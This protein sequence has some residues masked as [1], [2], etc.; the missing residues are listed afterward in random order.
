MKPIVRAAIYARYSS[1]NQ[2][3]ESITAQ[4]RACTE[5]CT[6]HDYSVVLTYVD[7]ARSALTDDR[8][9]FQRMIR[10]AKVGLFD[11]LVIHKLD[12]FARSRYDSAFYKREL[13]RASVRL[14]S[15]LERLDGSP[16]SIV[17]ESVLEGMAEYY[18]R[19]LAREIRKGMKE[20]AL[21]CKHNGGLPPLG[22]DVDPD[23]QYVINPREAQTVR[24]I[25]EMYDK[26]KTYS[27]I[28]EELH[29][30]GHRTKHGK[31][32][33]K[34]SLYSIL[35]NQKYAGIYIFNR[36]LGRLDGKF[37][38]RQIKPP[39]QII[40]VPGGIPAIID[41]ELFERVRA[42]ME[43]RKNQG[44]KARARAKQVYLLSGLIFCGKC[45]AAYIGNTTTNG[46]GRQYSFYECGARDRTRSCDNRRISKPRTEAAVL[47]KIDASIFAPAVRR[48]L[49]EKVAAYHQ[50]QL[51]QDDDE[52]QY[53]RGEI[54]R[55]D[56]VIQNL[57]KAV[58][59]GQATSTLLT[60]MGRRE[61]ERNTL[62][63]RLAQ[64]ESQEKMIVAPEQVEAYLAELQSS[65][66]R[67]NE[68]Q[69]KALV[70]DFVDRVVVKKTNLE[71]RLKISLVTDG[72][73]GAY[74]MVTKI[75]LPLR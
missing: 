4:V 38:H 13:R 54:K 55:A 69:L 64:L 68:A 41:R 63:G 19:N 42:R 46:Q 29:Q 37:R 31:P 2:R 27:T 24:I 6:A 5:Y 17:L 60:Q 48:K 74:T 44:E 52:L 14:E 23:K 70:Q 30:K 16:E 65:T 49:A 12:R 39:E 3:E 43:K 10:D 67:E 20:T 66:Q 28:I 15:V 71:V 50:E 36:S 58:E 1:D 40:Q 25:F 73:G 61:Q 51:H 7:E 22:Y 11:V 45:G 75:K 59:A 8:P 57:V 34:N 26:E 35:S 33:G 21:Q 32:F 9:E 72:S 47:K 62:L 53:L 18:S 56:G